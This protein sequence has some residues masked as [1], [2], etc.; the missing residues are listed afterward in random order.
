MAPSKKTL[1][2]MLTILGCALASGCSQTTVNPSPINP[3]QHAKLAELAA[4]PNAPEGLAEALAAADAN[5]QRQ[6]CQAR[7][8]DAVRQMKTVGAVSS[9]AGIA[10]GLAGSGGKAA[11]KA[12]AVGAAASVRGRLGQLQPC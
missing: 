6:A 8:D 12:V 7:I 9:A 5:Q 1:G 10:G 3:D 11:A 4:G 2:R